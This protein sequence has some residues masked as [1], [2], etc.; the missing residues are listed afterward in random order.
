MDGTTQLI[1]TDR[2]Y[3]VHPLHH[4]DDHRQPLVVVEG[5]GAMLSRRGRPRIHR[6]PVGAVERQCRPRPRRAGRRRGGADAPHRLCLGLYR[7]DQRAGGAAR[8]KDR[9]PR[10]PEFLRGLFHH[11][12]RR[13]QRIRVQVRALLLEGQRQARQDQDHLAHPRL[14]RRDD[15]GDERH[16]HGR[17][18]QDVR[19]AGAGLHP[20]RAAL[21]LSLAGQRRAGRSAPPR[22][23]RRRSSPRAP[24]RSR[25]SSPSR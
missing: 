14:S 16:R 2:R 17:L 18:P 5:K 9:R 15:G 12:R 20:G 19:A 24:T 23:S 3:L 22:R 8:R 25:R 4:P 21:R 11:R 13:I 6:Q 10:L 7:P 1:E